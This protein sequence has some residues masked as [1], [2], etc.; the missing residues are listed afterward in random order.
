MS[1]GNNVKF[2]AKATSIEKPV[3]KPKYIEGIKFDN[4]RIEKPKV[5]VIDV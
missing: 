5:I 2:A 1:N 3:N 4:T